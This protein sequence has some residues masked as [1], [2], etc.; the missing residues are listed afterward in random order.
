M[1]DAARPLD[2]KGLW[3]FAHPYTCKDKN[4]NYVQAGEEANFRICCIRSGELMKRGY[5]IYSPIAHTH[6]IHMAT[7]DFLARHEHEMWY[8][9]DNE[10]IEKTAW[11]GIILA[12]GWEK[13]SGCKAELEQFQKRGLPA[14]HY[15][16]IVSAH[17]CRELE[18][19][20]KMVEL[21]LADYDRE[22]L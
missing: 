10:V 1:S 9:L 20:L 5:N 4:G 19:V 16:Q 7:P 3:Y 22:E 6:P 18:N 13:S 14:L 2:S 8:R 11:T 15:T 12:P 21:C 17:E